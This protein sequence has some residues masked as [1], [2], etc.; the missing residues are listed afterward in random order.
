MVVPVVRSRKTPIP[1][2]PS[3]PSTRQR[4]SERTQCQ[5]QRRIPH[6]RGESGQSNQNGPYAAQSQQDIRPARNGAGGQSLEY[7]VGQDARSADT[8]RDRSQPVERPAR[9]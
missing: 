8:E 2:R 9:N 5:S 4:R 7:R 3:G 1:D 6:E